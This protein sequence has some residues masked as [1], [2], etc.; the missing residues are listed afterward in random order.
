LGRLN[1]VVA[2]PE[3]PPGE[4]PGSA[5]MRL[6]VLAL[7]LALASMLFGLGFGSEFGASIDRL[8]R[9]IRGQVERPLGEPPAPLP[10]GAGVG[11][12]ARAAERLRERLVE[13]ASA[14]RS[15][16]QEL[17][18]LGGE[19]TDLLAGVSAELHRPLER[20]VGIA[21]GLLAGTEG[22]LQK[23]Q[24][25]DVRIIRNAG[26]RLLKLVEEVV[27]LSALVGGDL[28]FDGAPVDLVELAREVVETARGQVGKKQLT[29]T[30]E[31]EDPADVITV[32]GNRQRLW[33]VVT[34]LVSNGIKF[35]ERGG[36]TVRLGREPDGSARLEVEDSGVGISPMDQKSIFES[37]RQLGGRGGRKSGTGLGLA[38]C[39]RLIELHG[40]KVRVSS[41]LAKGTKFTV[42]LPGGS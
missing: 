32:R 30:L 28:E 22:E 24:Q 18:S 40:G 13:E 8:R 9:W 15:A 35:T 19:R 1:V 26:Q 23:S 33:Q 31:R 5:L 42:I 27:D 38:I 16:H 10:A 3:R 12:V 41:M 20:V 17:E 2:M 7:V 36:V 11:E 34:N 4:Q 29:V 21:D 39:R 37:F 6:G 14:Y 25:E